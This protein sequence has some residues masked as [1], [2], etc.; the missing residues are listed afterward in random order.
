MRIRDYTRVTC[1]LHADMYSEV[2]PFKSASR[3]GKMQQAGA[4]LRLLAVNQCIDP[5]KVTAPQDAHRRLVLQIYLGSNT[6]DIRR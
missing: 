2:H 1:P 3:C 5:S 6:L 4:W